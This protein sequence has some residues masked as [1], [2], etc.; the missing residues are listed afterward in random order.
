M[1]AWRHATAGAFREHGHATGLGK[2]EERHEDDLPYIQMVRSDSARVHGRDSAQLRVD[3]RWWWHEICSVRSDS[4][5]AG[6][7]NVTSATLHKLA[8]GLALF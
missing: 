8:R 6:S 2:L 4:H 5:G 1:E 7:R 3:G